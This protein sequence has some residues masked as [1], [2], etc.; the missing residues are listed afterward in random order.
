MRKD[1]VRT[2]G[3]LRSSVRCWG[4]SVRRA[5]KSNPP[6]GGFFGFQRA[7]APH[8]SNIAAA[9]ADVNETAARIHAAETSAQLHCRT[10]YTEDSP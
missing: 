5:R 8:A 1:P 6:S 10:I 4:L 7:A 9:S 2:G 3:A